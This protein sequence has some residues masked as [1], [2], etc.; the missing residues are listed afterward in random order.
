MDE[1]YTA[2]GDIAVL[3]HHEPA[4]PL[5]FLPVHA[6]LLKG[7]EPILIETGLST[8]TE[9][10]LDALRAELDPGELRWIAITHEDLDHA[11]NL[12]P[13]LRRRPR[14]ASC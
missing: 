12:G 1:T 5:G 14:P 13:L 3:S 9:G 11:G 7:K 4:G 6:Y 2:A 8:Q 10:F